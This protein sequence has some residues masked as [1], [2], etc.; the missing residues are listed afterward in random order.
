MEAGEKKI[1]IRGEYYLGQEVRVD[2][3]HP[4]IEGFWYC[5]VP[6]L[7]FDRPT[8]QYHQTAAA[9]EALFSEAQLGPVSTN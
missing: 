6:V 1:V 5:A 3:P 7:R 9:V 8:R 4:T 2:R